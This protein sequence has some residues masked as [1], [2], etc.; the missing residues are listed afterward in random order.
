MVAG[1]DHEH[2]ACA[3]EVTGREPLDRSA[4]PILWFCPRRCAAAG[5]LERVCNGLH[6][7]AFGDVAEGRSDARVIFVTWEAEVDEP[8]AVDGAGHR[9]QNS[10]TLLTVLYQ[11]VVRRQD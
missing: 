5:N 3:G 2:S 9:L 4:F 1:I 8:L 6:L 11:L 7:P 10:D